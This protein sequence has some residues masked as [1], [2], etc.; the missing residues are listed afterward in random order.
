MFFNSAATFC[1]FA[2]ALPA[3][4]TTTFAS[5]SPSS[6]IVHCAM[7]SLFKK[8]FLIVMMKIQLT[9][10]SLARIGRSEFREN[11]KRASLGFCVGDNGKLG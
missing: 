1:R 4:L 3:G 8:L 2:I 9:K 10:S 6:E 7:N 11:R 5:R